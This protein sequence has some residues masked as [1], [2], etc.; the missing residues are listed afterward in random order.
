LAESG[1]DFERALSELESLVEKM[2]SGE[3]PLEQCL[4]LFEQGMRLSRDCQA[5]LSAAEQKVEQLMVA[6]GESRRIP[7]DESGESP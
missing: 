1:Q 3:L 5:A 6:D 2:E 4:E 7:L